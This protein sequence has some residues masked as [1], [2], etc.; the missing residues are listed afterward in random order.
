MVRVS[1]WHYSILAWPPRRAIVGP[2]YHLDLYFDP[3][4]KLGTVP[5]NVFVCMCMW[6]GWASW[7]AYSAKSESWNSLW[8]EFQSTSNLLKKNLEKVEAVPLNDVS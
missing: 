7:L 5:V 1:H 2:I 6:S 3:K 4:R 8:A